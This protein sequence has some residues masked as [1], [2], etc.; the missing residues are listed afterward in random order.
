MNCQLYALV[1]TLF[2][3]KFVIIST[4]S[5]FLFIFLLF[6]Q[7]HNS[8]SANFHYKKG[9]YSKLTLSCPLWIITFSFF[10]SFLF[11]FPLYF[12]F[13]PS[14]FINCFLYSSSFVAR[15]QS[16]TRLADSNFS[17]NANPC[18]RPSSI[19]SSIIICPSL[20]IVT[21]HER[22]QGKLC[23]IWFIPGFSRCLF[24]PQTL[25]Y[26]VSFL[27]SHV[28]RHYAVCIDPTVRIINS[29][30]MEQA[31]TALGIP[32]TE[33]ETYRKLNKTHN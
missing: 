4:Y 1:F 2:W 12:Y 24:L 10:C 6:L 29:I 25:K 32:E 17:V 11:E 7:G 30:K 5:R 31:M 16:S 21:A 20:V 14:S 18:L 8:T 26:P 3:R 9:N 19:P 23:E 22:S 28:Y 13:I 15:M 27:L 33:W